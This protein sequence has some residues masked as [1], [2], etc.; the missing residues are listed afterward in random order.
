MQ[1][2]T[3]TQTGLNHETTLLIT[4]SHTGACGVDL[5]EVFYFA[6]KTGK[7]ARES[8]GLPQVTEPQVIRHFVRLSNQNY[9]IDSGFYPLGSCTMK[10]N[11]RLN[12]KMARL[13]GFANIHPLQNEQTVQG[14]LELMY[15]LQHWLGTLTGLEAV[16][17]APA[18]GAQGELAGMLVIKKAH[19]VKGQAHRKVV[20][21]PDSAHGTNPA[22]AAICGFDI[23]V[24]PSDE[25]GLVNLAVFKELVATHAH[26]LAGIMITNPNTCGKFEKNI[27]EIDKTQ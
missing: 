18:A 20:L 13:P 15:N 26:E 27:V 10:H 11:P 5:P 25:E 3:P 23:K 22:T 1:N 19:E 4:Q 24:I 14:A 9:S 12:E 17:L 8:I 6:I 2:F 7:K 21:I 16:S